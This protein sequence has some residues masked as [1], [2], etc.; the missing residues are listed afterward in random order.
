MNDISK[1]PYRTLK[2]VSHMKNITLIFIIALAALALAACGMNEQSPDSSTAG[3]VIHT[4]VEETVGMQEC[5]SCHADAYNPSSLMNVVGDSPGSSGWLNGPHANGNGRPDLSSSCATACHNQL[6]EGANITAIESATGLDLGGANRPIISCE[7]CHGSGADHFGTG[8]V[9]YPRPD[10]SRCGQ[11][12]NKDFPHEGHPAGDELIEKYSTSRHAMS[13][14]TVSGY[15]TSLVSSNCG[16]CHTDEGTKG[17]EPDASGYT[18]VQCRTC[19][20]PHN[21]H[22]YL[23]S[24]SDDGFGN[25]ASAEYNTCTHCHET[26]VA[27]HGETSTH[28]WDDYQGN[29]R[30]ALDPAM[31]NGTFQDDGIMYDTHWDNPATEW[32]EGYVIDPADE[33][34]C[35]GCHD[36]HEAKIQ[37]DHNSEYSDSINQ[38]WASSAHGG[39]IFD[40]KMEAFELANSAAIS[41]TEIYE[42]T[43]AILNGSILNSPSGDILNTTGDVTENEGPAW[44]HYDFK[45][46]TG[47]RGNTGRQACQRCHTSTGFKNFVNN[48]VTGTPYNPAENMFYATGEQREMLYCWACHQSTA[49]DLRGDSYYHGHYDGNKLI[50]NDTA[51]YSKPADRILA[52]PDLGGSNICMPCH[53][54]RESG[55]AVTQVSDFTNSSSVS[56][57]YLT[58]G[59]VLFGLVGYENSPVA[60]AYDNDDLEFLHNKIGFSGDSDNGPCVACHMK[61]PAG[62]TMEAALYDASSL[63]YDIPAYESTCSACHMGEAALITTMNDA[64]AGF[65]AAL[66]ELK[67]AL[68]Y[69]GI[70]YA[71]AYPYFFNSPYDSGYSD[72]YNSSCSSNFPIKNWETGGDNTYSVSSTIVGPGPTYD[73]CEW[74]MG[75]GGIAGTGEANMGAAFNYT[76]LSH[77]PGAYVHNSKYTKRLIFDSIDALDGSMDG[78]ITVGEPAKTYLFGGTRQ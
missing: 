76:L 52:V 29:T 44:T 75:G 27:H 59:G 54:G 10:A 36:V 22:E 17:I 33:R 78:T 45:E 61:S 47:G 34:A 7:S 6:E 31:I 71:S 70:H 48:T 11:C 23:V 56:S 43:M 1:I 40:L 50:F 21:P 32:I 74:N 30:A 67:L 72:I 57:H 60:G 65:D 77:E 49:N 25:I 20:D 69:N 51:P 41:N 68:M 42:N 28:S 13:F 35:S 66:D 64:K 4:T 5:L 16:H 39:H 2:G 26:Q 24:S 63:L 46:K 62:H 73:D 15:S 37:E 19:H 18:P 55:V 8:Y 12:H 9:E 3:T 58:A 14:D 53:S 38:Q